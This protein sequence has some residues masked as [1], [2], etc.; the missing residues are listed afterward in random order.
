MF[1]S[2]IH[3]FFIFPNARCAQIVIQVLKIPSKCVLSECKSPWSY[4][5]SKT[6]FKFVG[7]NFGEWNSTNSIKIWY[8]TILKYQK[9]ILHPQWSHWVP[10]IVKQPL[11]PLLQAASILAQTILL[12][13][14]FF[15]LTNF[16]FSPNKIKN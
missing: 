15:F 3:L 11:T 7:P 10:L 4:W 13:P 1:T 9:F 2:N 12:S 14:N 6:Y 8:H 16:N 5:N